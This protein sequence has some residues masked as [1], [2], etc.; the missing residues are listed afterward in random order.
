MSASPLIRRAA[1]PIGVLAF[2]LALAPAASAAR[3]DLAGGDT[4]V[5]V[6]RGT[7]SAVTGAGIA[8]APTGAAEAT[9][10]RVRFPITGGRLDPAAGAGTVNHRGGLRFSRSGRSLEL[11]RFR[12][13]GRFLSALAGGD[14]VR[15]LRLRAGAAVVRRTATTTTVSSVRLE[16]TRAGAR[17][18]NATLGTHLFARGIALGTARV[19]A[20][21][22]ELF[23]EDGSTSLAVDPGAAS[24][25][26]SQGIVPGLVAPASANSDGSLA[27]PI[28]RGRVDAR[29]FAGLIRHSGGLSLTKGSTRVELTRFDVGIDGTPQLTALVGGSR[30]PILNLDLSD[31][32]QDVDGLNV[33]LGNVRATLTAEAASALNQAFGT[34]AFAEGLLLGVATVRPE[35]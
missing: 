5:R 2:L 31:L 20:R 9:G 12:I 34:T 7:L 33:T 18:L 30:V 19:H 25:L 14:R 10:R 6:D 21:L 23:I 27:F 16:L 1:P 8:I 26:A 22:A 35:L 11:T 24:A 17:A 15:I 28:T 4:N 29:T 13:Q 32:T 3:V